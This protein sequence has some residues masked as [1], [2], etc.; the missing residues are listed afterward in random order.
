MATKYHD[1]S[2]KRIHKLV[3]TEFSESRTMPK[4]G[5]KQMYWLCKCDCRNEK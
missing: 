5:R 3:V 4:S 2:G 1:F